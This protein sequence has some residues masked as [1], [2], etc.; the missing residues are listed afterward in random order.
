MLCFFVSVLLICIIILNCRTYIQIHSVRK[1][2]FAIHTDKLVRFGE[3]RSVKLA[4]DTDFTPIMYFSHGSWCVLDDTYYRWS[5]E[6]NLSKE[7]IKN[8][9]IV[10]DEFYI[11]TCRGASEIGCA[12][13]KKFFELD[14]ICNRYLHKPGN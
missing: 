12:Y 7:G 10:G 11:A 5:K 3:R 13:N 6:F 9:S 8:T 1:G 14:E 4:R 2:E